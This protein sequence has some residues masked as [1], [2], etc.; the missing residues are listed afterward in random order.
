MTIENLLQRLDKVKRRSADKWLACCPAHDDSSPSL[1]IRVLD[2]G[3][4]LIH[5]FGGC[6][7][8]E[9]LHEIGMSFSDLYPAPTDGYYLQKIRKPFNATDILTGVAFEVLIAWIFAK[10]LATNQQLSETERARLLVCAS[11]L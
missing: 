6:G 7:A 5:C 11:R 3:R 1:A 4:I 10:Q 2:D 8:A 9:V